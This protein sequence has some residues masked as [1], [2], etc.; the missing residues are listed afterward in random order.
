MKP[1]AVKVKFL[2]NTDEAW[3]RSPQP[4]EIWVRGKAT[5]KD[6]ESDSLLLHI[7]DT[8]G[9]HMTPEAAIERGRSYLRG[10]GA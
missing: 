8:G 3:G 10:I 9:E 7:I 4:A 1:H 6:D 2:D 5:D